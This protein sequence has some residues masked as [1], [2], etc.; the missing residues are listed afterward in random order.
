MQSSV[1]TEHVL[2]VPT[3]LFHRVGQFQGFCSDVG[4]YLDVLLDPKQVS[5]RPRGEVEQDP[6]FK[7]LIP[8]VIFSCAAEAGDTV[9]Q[10]TRGS[11]QDEGRLRRKRSIGV[12]GHISA[13]DG[14]DDPYR[15]GMQRELEEEVIIDAGHT[16]RCVGLIN[17]DENDVGRVHLGVVHLVSVDRPA[18]F[19]RET[20][21]QACEFVPT[22]KLHAEI[23][24]FET[25]S[26]ICI[27]ALFSRC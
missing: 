22:D 12:G 7:Q 14:V 25:W 24:A 9:F 8:Y 5:F 20:E 11:K 19:P 15:Q 27:E 26:Q 18:V 16:N 4:K 10:Y 17:D 23:D 13:I 21:M 1:D 6:S 3:A 2:V